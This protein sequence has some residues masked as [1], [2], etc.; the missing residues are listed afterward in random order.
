MSLQCPLLL[1][2]VLR[3]GLAGKFER[4]RMNVPRRCRGAAA[5]AAATGLALHGELNIA[6][7]AGENNA[8]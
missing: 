3:E 5:A 4:T 6:H 7:V 2:Q 8:L 1:S